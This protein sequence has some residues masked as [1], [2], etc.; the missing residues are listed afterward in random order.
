MNILIDLKKRKEMF[1]LFRK[2]VLIFLI[3]T[4]FINADSQKKEY[5]SV[6][7]LDCEIM[8]D[9][10]YNIIKGYKSLL[11]KPKNILDLSYYVTFMD[12]NTT[13]LPYSFI[14][15]QKNISKSL[16]QEGNLKVA[17]LKENTENIEIET[18]LI[19]GNR[20]FIMVTPRNK[21]QYRD[22]QQII[23]SCNNTWEQKKSV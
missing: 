14:K 18:I 5:K 16:E 6:D 3:F 11:I 21:E 9:S 10:E 22:I 23:D 1:Y 2:L 17:T 19:I 20:F 13:N 8:V 12:E 4:L 7:L 15:K